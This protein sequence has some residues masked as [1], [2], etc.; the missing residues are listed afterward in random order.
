MEVNLDF[1]YILCVISEAVIKHEV[2]RD[3][4]V[5][6]HAL[7]DAGIEIKHELAHRTCFS[8]HK[9]FFFLHCEHRSQNSG[10]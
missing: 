4:T 6:R 2:Q 10:K 5:G 1:L 8:F 7:W 9:S 3:A